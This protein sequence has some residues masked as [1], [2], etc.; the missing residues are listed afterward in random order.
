MIVR[1]KRRMMERM[2]SRC[3]ILIENNRFLTKQ[4]GS[5]K[6]E[7]EDDE[8][9]SHLGSYWCIRRTQVI[10]GFGLIHKEVV[11]SLGGSLTL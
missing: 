6:K 5:Q 7:G 3:F 11:I 1:L 9:M 10:Q 4:R 8:Y 2:M